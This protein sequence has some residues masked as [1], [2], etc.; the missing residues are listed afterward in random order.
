MWTELEYGLD[1]E[2]HRGELYLNF[3]NQAFIADYENGSIYILKP[4][5][6]TDNG[7]AIAREIVTRHLFKGNEEVVIDE[8]YVDMEVGVGLA[9]GQGSDP[10]VMLQISKNNGRT[11][12]AELWKDL[13][14]IGEYLTRVVWRRL[15]ISRDWLFKIRLT[16]PCKFVMVFT[17][18]K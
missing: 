13:G 11:W 2:R 8:A 15:G 4:D 3:I 12:S 14:A 5:V 16:D 6:Y 1:G 9:T 10:Q 7:G 17:D 18:V